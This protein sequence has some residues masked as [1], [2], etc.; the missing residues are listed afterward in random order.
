MTKS[1]QVSGF[2]K[3]PIEK[4]LEFLKEF[5]SLSDEDVSLLKKQSALDLNLAD[6]M[7]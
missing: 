7:V 1:S 6:K 2:Y 3:L 4:R 5:A